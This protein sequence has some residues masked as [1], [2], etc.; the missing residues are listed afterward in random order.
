MFNIFRSRRTKN[1]RVYFISNVRSKM[2]PEKLLKKSISNKIFKTEEFQKLFDYSFPYS[3]QSAYLGNSSSGVISRTC[4][5]NTATR[6]SSDNSNDNIKKLK[7]NTKNAE[8]SKHIKGYIAVFFNPL[9]NE[10][11]QPCV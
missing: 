1:K 4:F 5:G 10:K 6:I 2:R 11:K 7:V 9:K 3:S 8:K